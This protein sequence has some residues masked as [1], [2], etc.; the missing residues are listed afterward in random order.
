MSNKMFLAMMGGLT[1]A[2]YMY[3]NKKPNMLNDLK[4]TTKNIA[5]TTY[6]KLDNMN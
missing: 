2:G 1:I 3:M 4:N 6:E 5:K